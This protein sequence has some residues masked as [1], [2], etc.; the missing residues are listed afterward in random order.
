VL[1]NRALV[2]LKGIMARSKKV[3]GSHVRQLSQFRDEKIVGAA[4]PIY[5]L[6]GTDPF[7]LDQGRAAVRR[8]TIGDA[9][10]GMALMEVLGADAQLGDVL[11]AVR[12]LPFLAPHRLVLIREAD[13][14][15]DEHTREVLLK[16][17]ESPSATGSLCLESSTWNETT[18][19]A[20]KVAEVGVVVSCEI[21]DLSKIPSW[22]RNE[23]KKR[24]AKEL[25]PG[26]AQM[27]VEYLGSD[28]ASLVAAL[29]MLALYA[30]SAPGIDAPEVD[31]LIARGHHE[32]IW[33]LCDAIADRR[34][35]KA[36]E[37]LD[38]FWT[39][40]M[41]APQ[42]IGAIRPTFRMLVRV[43]ALTGRMG[44]DPA[45]NAAAVPYPARDRVRRAV[46]QMSE[47][48]LAEAYQA[49]VDADLEA[50]STPND[51]LAMETLIHRLTAVR[52]RKEDT[53]TLRH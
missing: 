38:T 4:L 37:L 34:L 20:K 23:A 22:L 31:A 35:A 26:A 36:L 11:D 28:F 18:R 17:L 42:I 3:D 44:L 41:V 43:K 9:D 25:T 15:I 10:P 45:M 53:E 19:L 1:D 5:V 13:E 49:L 30:A 16:Y 46:A 48:A 6:R 29:D 40:G 24:Y 52:N 2:G 47:A 12:T 14:F 27:L 21:T 8:R 39:E 50:K 51:R 33:S 32:M 7:L